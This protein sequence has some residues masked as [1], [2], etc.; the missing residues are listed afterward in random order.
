MVKTIKPPR[1][2]LSIIL[3]STKLKSEWIKACQYQ[4][5]YPFLF[6]AKYSHKWS[7]YSHA[8]KMR[9]RFNKEGFTFICDLPISSQHFARL[10]IK[11]CHSF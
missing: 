8:P 4:R 6:D 3:L 2:F 7:K 9:L 10:P 11:T 5:N 1:E